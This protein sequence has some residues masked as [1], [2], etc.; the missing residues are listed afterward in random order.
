[1]IES[2]DFLTLLFSMLPISGPWK[3]DGERYF[4]CCCFVVGWFAFV[5]GVG[6][7]FWNLAFVR[8]SDLGR[9]IF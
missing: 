1:M 4:R 9:W 8:G 2:L 5:F 3:G 7:G 6:V